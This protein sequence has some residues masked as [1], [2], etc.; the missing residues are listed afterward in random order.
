MNI[1]I[2]VVG[3]RDPYG[4]EGSEGSILTAARHLRPERV[5]LLPTRTPDSS[6]EANAEQTRETLRTILPDA[7]VRLHPLVLA[8]PTDYGEINQALPAAVRDVLVEARPGDTLHCAISSGTPQLRM[9]LMVLLQ[10]RARG[11][12]FWETRAPRY[13][14]PD[15]PRIEQ[16]DLGFL[17]QPR[18]TAAFEHAW[19]AH[20][21]TGAA[22][23]LREQVDRQPL[24][25]NVPVLTWA[26][27]LAEAYARW[28]AVDWAD[29]RERLTAA[30]NKVVDARSPAAPLRPVLEQQQAALERL[31]LGGREDYWKMLD[32]YHNACR[33]LR[34]GQYVDALA[35]W[36]RVLE[37]AL[38]AYIR[39]LP[40][41]AIDDDGVMTLTPELMDG[42]RAWRTERHG[43]GG[44]PVTSSA[45]IHDLIY[46]AQRAGGLSV[47]FARAIDGLVQAR[48]K[49]IA[50]HGIEPVNEAIARSALDQL[51]EILAALFPAEAAAAPVGTYA[52]G[53]A[54]LQRIGEQVLTLIQRPG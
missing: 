44:W 15:R 37:G 40:D 3:M 52:F 12:R 19:Q 5:H 21:F 50:A 14:T 35:R 23:I 45:S 54:E 49:S 26:A 8:D 20:D 22:L 29:A 47:R 48:N 53:A 2:S 4:D 39:N 6:T 32:L 43:N 7:L 27:E 46:V 25:P 10:E 51:K 34:A 41:C 1:L 30:R 16:I 13:V 17:E 18:A 31:A 9:M 24:A 28:D 38:S 36:R 42:W 11:T 33:R